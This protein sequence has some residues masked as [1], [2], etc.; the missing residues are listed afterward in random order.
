MLTPRN[1]RTALVEALFWTGG[2]AFVA[3]AD[4]RSGVL[5]SVCV[6][7]WISEWIGT[8]F[9]PGCGLGQAV[10]LLVRGEWAASWAKHPLAIPAVV[11]LARHAAGLFRDARPF[12][13]A[14]GP[15]TTH[16]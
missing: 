8:A 10:G 6:F 11:L 5:P 1:R 13:P 3:L 16:A 9:C 12:Y 2:L 7:H 14:P 15:S 4:P